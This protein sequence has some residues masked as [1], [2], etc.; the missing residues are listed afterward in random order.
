MLATWETL[1]LRLV[2][3]KSIKSPLVV[4]VEM[5]SVPPKISEKPPFTFALIGIA[6]PFLSA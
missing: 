4:E 3:L 6:V 5:S 1:F 2:I